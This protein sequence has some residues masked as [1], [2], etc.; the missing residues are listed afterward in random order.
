MKVFISWSGE[1]SR[2]IARALAG[3]PDLLVLDEPTAG[4]DLEHQEV[5]AQLLGRLIE[6]GTA[7]LV[8]LHEVGALAPLIGRAV[9]LRDGR[10]VHDGA[11]GVLGSG[12][13]SG[14]EHQHPSRDERFLDGAVD[15]SSRS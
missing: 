6:A 7:V 3:E 11:L 12:H 5:L 10:V 2:L 8:V 1:L 15:R 4:V 14:H 9:L 13:H